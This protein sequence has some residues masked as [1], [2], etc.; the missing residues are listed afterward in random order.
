MHRD[1]GEL[2][3]GEGI[4]PS[5]LSKEG[6]RGRRCFFIIGVGAGKFLGCEGF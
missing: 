3:H 5:A 4:L 1:S 6:Q 2:R